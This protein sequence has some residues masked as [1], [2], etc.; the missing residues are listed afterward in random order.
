[1]MKLFN[2]NR[3]TFFDIIKA[4]FYVGVFVELL[5]SINGCANVPVKPEGTPHQSLTNTRRGGRQTIIENFNNIEGFNQINGPN[6]LIPNNRKTIVAAYK[7][8]NGILGMGKFCELT[9]DVDANQ[10]AMWETSLLNYDISQAESL[11]F[12]V[13]FDNPK[14][15]DALYCTLRDEEG[16]EKTTACIN[17]ILPLEFPWFEIVIPRVIFHGVD[18]NQLKS[19]SIE[20]HANANGIQWSCATAATTVDNKYLPNN[21]RQ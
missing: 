19:C 12:F 2:R 5:I 15:A 11:A 6:V 20:I 3:D 16:A 1:M 14:T 13:R 9:F 10:K 8:D 4:V 21:C 17:Y 18:F 7:K